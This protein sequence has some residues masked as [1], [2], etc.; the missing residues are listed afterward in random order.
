M[1]RHKKDAYSRLYSSSDYSLSD[2]FCCAALRCAS[3]GI[4]E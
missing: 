2:R 4:V 3:K 1:K